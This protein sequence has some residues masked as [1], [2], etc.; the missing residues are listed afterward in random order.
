MGTSR[1]IRLVVAALAVSSTVASAQEPAFTPATYPALTGA[2]DAVTVDLD[3]DGW[4]D[5]ATANAG[6]NAV[7]L[8]INRGPN[9]GFEAPREIGVGAGPFDL[10]AGD[11]DRNGTPDLVVTTPD[12]STI[13]V[14]LLGS[15]GE[16]A[17][18]RVLTGVGEAWGATL[19]DVTRD[20]ILDIVHSDYATNSI[21]VLRGRGD[22]SFE[23]HITR[24]PVSSRPQGVAAADFNHD[25]I[26]DLAVASTGSSSL[27]VL[28][29]TPSG[30]L[31]RTTIA[32][33][34]PLNVLMAADLDSDGWLDLAAASSSTGALAILRG[35]ASG[36][37][38]AGTRATG[39]SPRGVAIGDLNSDGRLDVATANYSVHSVTL[40]LG[41]ASGVLPD[42]WGDLPSAPGARAI[43]LGDFDH[44][45]RPDLATG[46]QSASRL[47]IHDNSTVVVRGGLSFHR[48]PIAVFGE[49]LAAGDVNENGRTD[50][51][52]NGAVLLDGATRVVLPV[53]A[54]HYVF[55]SLL[56]DYTRDGHQDA[57][58][59]LVALDDVGRLVSNTVALYAGDGRGRFAPPVALSSGRTWVRELRAGD[60]D[61]DGHP[62]I[63]FA[64]DATL[65]VL[66]STG[67]GAVMSTYPLN[68]MATWFELA[69]LDRD[70][71]LDI[72]VAADERLIAFDGDGTGGFAPRI[73]VHR[74]VYQFALGDLDHDGWLD[75]ATDEPA[76]T[77][78]AIGVMLG[79]PDGTFGAAVEYPIDTHFDPLT[80][81]TLGDFTG[82]GHLDAVSWGGTLLTGHGDGSFGGPEAFAFES[83]G[84]FALDWN[85]DGLLDLVAGG[86]ALVNE[87]RNVNRPPVANAGPDATYSYR[88]HL[89]ATLYAG[90]SS[91][92]DL[93]RLTYDWRDASGMPVPVDEDEVYGFFPPRAPGTHVFTLT[94]RDGRGGE[95]TD[96]VA[97]TILPA[98]EIVIHAGATGNPSGRWMITDDSSAASAR[99][100]FYPNAGAPKS[101]APAAAPTDSVDIFFTPDP[102][103]TYK[104][105]V[106]LKAENNN[107]ANDSV[108]L[109]FS[110]A[111][112]SSGRAVSPIGTTSGMAVNLEEC[113]GCGVSGW[114]WEDDGWGA[115]N[116]NGG[117]LR[118]PEGGYQWIRIQVREDGVSIDQIVLSA[119]RY[120][121]VRP[122]TAKGDTTILPE[123]R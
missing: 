72:L 44:D 117:L 1:S 75:L 116:V 108:W 89:S 29:G 100:L 48:E 92:P 77:G 47:W 67:T 28:L 18:R 43:A 26:T 5:V 50:L 19:A 12:S 27:D 13:D 36:F 122:G 59:S 41:R 30:G 110:G 57:V 40:L 95:D 10:S 61:R 35:S 102:T 119:E 80:G 91:D 66:R 11:V 22:G 16:L 88:E 123:T 4:L 20:G 14:L 111:T 32:V 46:G 69:D 49:S 94:V 121:T 6:R 86:Q 98:P 99:R 17:S 7:V 120:R 104:L 114:G 115:R 34:R 51:A 76:F 23:P 54:N 84:I 81:V 71:S 56:V 74:T 3:R 63:V 38:L 24:Q 83:R 64:S 112:D 15:S 105:W 8:L 37:V 96:T 85:R 31:I 113:S 52:G 90:G 9:G 107:W 53:P 2:R 106:R 78:N 118:F 25:G 79:L 62:D 103:Q 45:G 68:G 73:V 21:S 42:R 109:Q 39:A 97:I 60:I 101:T 33:G 82:D 70:G 58:L 93:H 65:H 87:R 55:G